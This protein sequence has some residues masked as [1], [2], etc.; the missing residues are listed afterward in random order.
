MTDI[1][2]LELVLDAAVY[3]W[4]QDVAQSGRLA[5]AIRQLEEMMQT[6]KGMP[7]QWRTIR[8]ESSRSAP[9]G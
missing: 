8:H 1:E 7:D 4:A 6:W 3:T 9:R 5:D 2:A